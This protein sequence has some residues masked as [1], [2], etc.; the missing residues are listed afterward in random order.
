MDNTTSSKTV[1]R[2]F[3]LS[4]DSWNSAIVVFGLLVGFFSLLAGGATYIAFQLQ[5]QEAKAAQDDLERYKADAG[6]AIS[7]ANARA[8]E[9]QLELEKLKAP[10]S[11]SDKQIGEI[12]P[13]LSAFK[14]Q[15]YVITTFWDLKEPLAL[16]E[17]LH[18]VLS[19][20]G[21]E[22]IKPESQGFLLG[23]MAGVQVWVHPNADPK[24]KK[25][26]DALMA[27]LNDAALAPVM[28][29]QNPAN[30]MDNKIAI[31]VGTKP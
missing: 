4:L 15:G 3:G 31:N 29:L 25:A 13:K 7:S 30:Q 17:R 27:A 11:I 21:W 18:I 8:L 6:T 10:R 22:F 14:G 19:N 20:A 24:V 1:R 23:G 9:A 28:K 2:M 5:K 26:A 12:L 16:A